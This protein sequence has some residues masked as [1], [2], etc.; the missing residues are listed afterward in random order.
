M[1]TIH[2]KSDAL[3]AFDAAGDWI[4]GAGPSTDPD[5]IPFNT[6]G[7][8]DTAAS[9]AGVDKSKT[10]K[11]T[12]L[13]SFNGSDGAD[14]FGSLITDAAGDLFGTTNGG[15]ANPSG[16]VFEI[17]K[18][19]SGYASTPISL[20]TFTGADGAY[21]AASLIADAAGDLFGTTQ[22]GGAD[23]DGTV[24]EIAK[25]KSG[26]A[27]VPTTLV[28]FTGADGQGP[29][30]SLIADA[31]GDLFG[32]T[33]QGGADNDGT[34][35]EI[36]KTKS[37]YTSAPTTLIS[38]TR[39]NGAAPYGS[40]TA[41]AAG[42]LFGTTYQG[43]AD[44]DGTVFEIAKTRNGYA[45][46]PTTL[47]SFTGSDGYDP[48][49][50]LIADAAGDL[51]GTTIDGGTNG[52]GT[53]FELARTKGGYASAPT[54][55]VG[56]TG[57]DGA[58]PYGDLIADAAGNLFGTTFQGGA[59]N[60]GV[61]FEIAKTKSGYASTPTTLVT[62]T[63]PD[64]EAPFGSLIADAAGDLL[65]TTS[66]GG[67][68]AYGTVFEITNSGFVPPAMP[69]TPA[70]HGAHSSPPGAAF[71]QAMASFGPS[72][73]GDTT[74]AFLASRHDTSMHLSRPHVAY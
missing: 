63:G 41:D 54:I 26:Y 3:A 37:G 64:G 33:Y 39:A 9:V 68:D 66:A 36:A 60:D 58:N 43:G 11:L 56:F 65:G 22:D 19:K 29:L 32:T 42:D 72:G 40:L 6:G 21:P 5:A 31:A 67:A 48:D 35:F 28:S 47:V 15:G 17:A 70:T 23:G 59:D 38:F 57:A 27:S 12:T 14:P 51:F 10:P 34:V 46:A 25:T 49:G 7:G 53:V 20:I 62:F 45:S 44:N 2:W 18:T 52:D 50:S 16:T 61:V 8:V 4:G 55:L 24:F 74:P 30:G 13:A 73:S 69:V 1:N 71:V